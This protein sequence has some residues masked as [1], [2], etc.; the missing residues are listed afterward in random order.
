[1]AVGI[2]IGSNSF[3]A[4]KI[5]CATKKK[6]AEYE[7]VVRTAEE[8]ESTAKIGEAAIKRIIDAFREVEELFGEFDKVRAVSTAAFRKA[9]NS[10]EV[11]ERIEKAT[12]IAVEII[13][14]ETESL[15]SV[16]G[17]EF[18]LASKGIATERFLMADIGGASTE[19]I[20]KH[21]KDILFRSFDLGI[22][23]TIQRFRSKEEIV[24]GIRRK[25][26]DIQE[27]L[28][29]AYEL[30]GKPKI[31]AG[32]GGTPATVAALKLGLSYETYDAAKVSG[33]TIDI[34]DIR[35]AYERLKLLDPQK[36]AKLVGTGREDAIMAGLVILEELMRHAGYKKMV[37]CD[38]GVREGAALSLCE[39]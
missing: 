1:M 24:F 31:F 2:D 14:E 33:A 32:T 39:K 35:S 36:R 13:D 7:K 37:V 25:M 10:Q 22:L 23:T 4:V 15:L 26:A 11:R 9:K 5:D 21:R 34:T 6:L 29:D 28:L 3:R 27:F 18:G 12:G 8:L 17:V 16:K 19:L 20:L 30:F 38:E